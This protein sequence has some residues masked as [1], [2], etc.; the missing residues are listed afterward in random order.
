MSDAGDHKKAGRRRLEY[1]SNGGAKCVGACVSAGTKIGQGELRLGV[2]ID[3]DNGNT[4][5]IWRHWGCVAP[6]FIKNTKRY[7]E[8]ADEIEGF[9]DLRPE[10][11]E[12]VRKA[13]AEGKVADEDIPESAK[14]PTGAAARDPVVSQDK[15]KSSIAPKAS[16]WHCRSCLRDPCHQPTATTCGHVFCHR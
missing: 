2:L 6:V 10:D 8:K 13:W 5:F 16:S 1:A 12:K 7:F 9:K 11:Q 15:A 3:Y 4:G 14:K